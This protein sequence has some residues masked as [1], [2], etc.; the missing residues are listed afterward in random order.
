MATKASGTLVLTIEKKHA[1]W[2]HMVS[3]LPSLELRLW[4]RLRMAPRHTTPRAHEPEWQSLC[5]ELTHGLPMAYIPFSGLLRL[6]WQQLG[7]YLL[8]FG[9]GWLH[10]VP[11]RRR[12]GVCSE[13]C[14]GCASCGIRWQSGA[15]RLHH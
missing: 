2:G 9:V 4:C 5:V 13:H 7:L 6:A 12:S 14:D 11:R 15:C 3:A 8:D 1:P 10:T